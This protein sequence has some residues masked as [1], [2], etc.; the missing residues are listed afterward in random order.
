MTIYADVI[1][2]VNLL[3]DYMLL[4]AT[5]YIRRVPYKKWR[6]V[7]SSTCGAMYT[8]FI[9]FPPLSFAY[10]I[11]AKFIFSCMMIWLVFGRIR[12]WGFVQLLVTFYFISFFIGGGLFALHFFL[13][14]KSQLVN[15]IIVTHSGSASSVAA[16][17]FLLLVIGFPAMW[18]LTKKGYRSVEASRQKDVQYVEFTVEINEYTF[19][20]TGFID[21]GNQLH[22]PLSRTPVSIVELSVLES[23]LPAQV[24]AAVK[25][26]DLSAF[27]L[28]MVDEGWLPRMRLIPYRTVSAQMRFLLAI[29]PDQVIVK[30]GEET[31][32]TK[33][34]IGLR[35]GSL[36][37]DGSYQAVVHPKA[38][39]HKKAS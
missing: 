24:T 18:W 6:M 21:T 23:I 34:F 27:D 12:V 28:S 1:F 8:I 4:A 15:E 16:P 19:S 10:T 22:D 29:R 25:A 35:T 26:D 13:Q 38:L 14:G 9:F 7:A 31:Y 33:M 3:I 39:I 5:A 32:H 36:A 30:T 17:T 20:C 2:A 37:S 11:L